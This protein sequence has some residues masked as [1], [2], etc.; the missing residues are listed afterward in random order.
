MGYDEKVLVRIS[1][2]NLQLIITPKLLKITKRHQI[3]CGCEIFIQAGTYQE[4]INHWCKR[5]LRYINNH[6]NS[7]TIISVEQLNTENIFSSYS[8]VVLPYVELINPCAKDAAFYSMS[9]FP[10]N[11]IK[12]PMWSCMLNCCSIFTVVFA[13]GV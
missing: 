10:E 2:S 7:L 4:L 8:D 13:P 5:R 3:I 12:L 1:D 11:D 9:D 6:A